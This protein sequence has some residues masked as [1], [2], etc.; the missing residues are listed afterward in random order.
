[1]VEGSGRQ[2]NTIC[3]DCNYN[4]GLTIIFIKILYSLLLL[5]SINDFDFI[6]Y[7]YE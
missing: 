7:D 2:C 6:Y 1:M 4:N 5:V 3:D